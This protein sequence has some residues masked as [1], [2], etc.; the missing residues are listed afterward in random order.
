MPNGK[1]QPEFVDTLRKVGE[2][3]KKYGAT[4]YD[5]R[6]SVI[7][8]QPWGVITQKGNVL[9]AHI[10]NGLKEPYLFI[11]GL[12]QKISRVNLFGNTAELKFKQQP[13]GVFVYLP[14]ST[15]DDIDTIIQLQ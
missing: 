7:A 6:G 12:K 10:L 14:N 3:M 9:Y 4:I 13:E 11:A 8:P 15:L 1:I 2:W 5:T